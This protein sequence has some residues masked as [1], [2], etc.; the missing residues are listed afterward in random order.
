MAKQTILTRRLKASTIANLQTVNTPEAIAKAS[1]FVYMDNLR[2]QTR[3]EAAIEKV[4]SENQ[5]E[6]DRMTDPEA[7]KLLQECHDVSLS[8]L[9]G[10][11]RYLGLTCQSKVQWDRAIRAGVIKIPS[12]DKPKK[13]TLTYTEMEDDI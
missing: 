10:T 12:K 3:M 2:L 13:S 8:G 1:Q 4:A 11:D 5:Q 9:R 7:R 6:I